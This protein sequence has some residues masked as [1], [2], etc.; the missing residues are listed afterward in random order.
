MLIIARP[1]T[2]SPRGLLRHT[3]TH[4]INV[5][6]SDSLQVRARERRETQHTHSHSVNF[7]FP[8]HS[9]VS[10]ATLSILPALKG[11][12]L[13]LANNACAQV[14]LLRLLILPAGNGNSFPER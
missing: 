7:Q 12:A 10:S 14:L 3:C 1:F 6:R 8:I 2:P 13:E 4:N 5:Y 9:G 11:K